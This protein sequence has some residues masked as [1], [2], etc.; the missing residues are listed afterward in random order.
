MSHFV[1]Y[2]NY[3][4]S[5]NETSDPASSKPIPTEAE[6]FYYLITIPIFIIY[7][8]I[9]IVIIIA[10]EKVT[11][12]SFFKIQTLP[13]GIIYTISN[14]NLYGSPKDT[15]DLTPFCKVMTNIRSIVF[16]IILGI[17]TFQML[18]TLSSLYWSS[19]L[20]KNNKIISVILHILCHIMWIVM[21]L[22]GINGSK[23]ER[24]MALG[25]CKFK[26]E[27]V[28]LYRTILY[29]V[30]AIIYA[31]SFFMMI[32]KVRKN[33][34]ETK[35][36][37]IFLKYEKSFKRYL[38]GLILYLFTYLSITVMMTLEGF[39]KFK[40]SFNTQLGAFMWYIRVF[41]QCMVPAVVSWINCVTQGKITRVKVKVFGAKHVKSDQSIFLTTNAY[42]EEMPFTL[43]GSTQEIIL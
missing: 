20:E 17:Q 9:F 2:I 39:T 23:Y 24:N 15:S 1:S 30:Y 3:L 7:I 25:L 36:H 16:I 33:L 28:T 27:A 31:F 38:I 42:L 21:V 43:R 22:L 5:N 12:H 4:T 19:F 26:N 41:S 8:F 14:L 6:I 40:V 37:T 32:Y 10:R 29:I 11:I 35:D 34:K 13:L 18:F